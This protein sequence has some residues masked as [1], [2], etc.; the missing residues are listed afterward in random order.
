MLLKLVLPRLFCYSTN[1][2][3]IT[4]NYDYDV[5]KGRPGDGDA[6]DIEFYFS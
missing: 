3:F 4:F 1:P 2:L 6:P 5:G